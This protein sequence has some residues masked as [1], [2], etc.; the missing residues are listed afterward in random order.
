MEALRLAKSH[1]AT[2]DRGTRQAE[3]PSSS[4]DRFKK[5]AMPVFIAFPQEDPEQH[6]LFREVASS[7][8]H[9]LLVR[10]SGL[11]NRGHIG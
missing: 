9:G 1:P 10:V 11:R 4:H 8:R 5:G 3:L 2:Q 7:R 6:A